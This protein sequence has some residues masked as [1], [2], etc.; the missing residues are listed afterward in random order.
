MNTD[1]LKNAAK[2]TAK[3]AAIGVPVTAAV[4]KGFELLTKAPTRSFNDFYIV[5]MASASLTSW[6]YRKSKDLLEDNG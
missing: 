4:K 1:K 5:A 6:V 2:E 3:F